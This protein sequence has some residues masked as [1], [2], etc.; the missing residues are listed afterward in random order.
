MSC[1]K[2]SLTKSSW[3]HKVNMF[4]YKMYSF[5][6]LVRNTIETCTKIKLRH[7]PKCWRSILN[8]N[9]SLPLFWWKI[10]TCKELRYL[11]LRLTS[12]I[13]PEITHAVL[14]FHDPKCLFKQF[15]GLLHWQAVSLPLAPPGKP[16][17]KGYMEITILWYLVTK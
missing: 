3:V 9:V 11:E 13:H 17:F 15:L 8:E 4:Q 5:I 12:P 2:P 10:G 7:I 1:H 14:A 6:I 16:S